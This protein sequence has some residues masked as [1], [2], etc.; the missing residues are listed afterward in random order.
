MSLK[1]RNKKKKHQRRWIFGEG[2]F[3]LLGLPANAL[4][5]GGEKLDEECVEL[6]AEV[7][8]LVEDEKCREVRVETGPH[9]VVGLVAERPSHLEHVG[10]LG[11]TRPAL[12]VTL[13]EVRQTLHNN[14]NNN[15]RQQ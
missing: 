14:N 5:D 10:R 7:A 3:E 15:K 1:I 8:V 9:G 11:N 4:H 13:Q 6:V 2:T 12:S